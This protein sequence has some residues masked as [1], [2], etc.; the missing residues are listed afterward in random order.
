MNSK[1]RISGKAE[2]I[3]GRSK[4]NSVEEERKGFNLQTRGPHEN[5]LGRVAK[6]K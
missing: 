5:C 2:R 1:K 3:P 4:L 6:N